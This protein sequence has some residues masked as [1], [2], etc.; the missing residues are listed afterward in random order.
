MFVTSQ[1]DKGS[2]STHHEAFR[3]RQAPTCAANCLSN[4]GSCKCLSHHTSPR[5]NSTIVSSHLAL[6]VHCIWLITTYLANILFG[7]QIQRPMGHARKADSKL[8]GLGV[9]GCGR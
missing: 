1:L 3:S 2:S 6:K 8:S 7:Y 5:T 4:A 9:F